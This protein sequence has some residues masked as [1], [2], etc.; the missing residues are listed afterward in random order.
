MEQH[1]VLKSLLDMNPIA[2]KELVNEL[3]LHRDV[4]FHDNII[5]FHGITQEN[6]NDK[7]KSYLLV[8][9]YA[10]ASELSSAVLCLH[11]EGIIHCDLHSCNVLVRNH[12]V[13]LA[14][15]GFS[16]RI[17]EVSRSLRETPI[18]H[19]PREYVDIYTECWNGVPEK[20]PTMQQV[21]AKLKT[22]STTDVMPGDLSSL[23]DKF[24]Q[25][26]F[27]SN[28]NADGISSAN[29]ETIKVPYPPQITAEEVFD[30]NKDRE[31]KKV[32]NSFM[33]YRMALIKELKTQN[34]S[35]NNSFNISVLAASRWS[36][37][38]DEVKQ[39]YKDIS[40]RVREIIRNSI[41]SNTINT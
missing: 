34:I 29:I 26:N 13:K 37:E 16:R 38:L 19:T 33:V 27:E 36:S 7:L 9:E 25:M 24:D 5:S 32:P 11:D 1:L 12:T 21:V 28:G 23:M 22:I 30:R 18:P 4:N 15:F 20:R 10:D 40:D 35:N 14:N 6:P 8:M 3:K 39:A 41:D 31:R 17:D 2:I